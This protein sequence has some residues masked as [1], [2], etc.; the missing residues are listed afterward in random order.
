VDLL[1]EE[2][3]LIARDEFGEYD[4]RPRPA[5]RGPPPLEGDDDEFAE[6]DNLVM[7]HAPP[8]RRV[9]GIRPVLYPV[10]PRVLVHGRPPPRRPSPAATLHSDFVFELEQHVVEMVADVRNLLETPE[11]ARVQNVHYSLCVGMQRLESGELRFDEMRRVRIAADLIKKAFQD[12]LDVHHPSK[13]GV[14]VRVHDPDLVETEVMGRAYPAAGMISKVI[15]GSLMETA[16]AEF[17]ERAH[18]CAAHDA[19]KEAIRNTV[20]SPERLEE[21]TEHEVM[22]RAACVVS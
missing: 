13:K 10:T 1:E 6:F 19:I 3:E 22:D 9:D 5:D 21:G 2:Q 14:L 7:M 8:R 15:R 18:H 20:E 4:A 17:K 11:F 12:L 16:R